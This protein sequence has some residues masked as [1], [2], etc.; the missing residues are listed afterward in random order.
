MW[1]TIDSVDKYASI[2]DHLVAVCAILAGGWWFWRQAVR[3][4]RV[5]FDIAC[6]F[7]DSK[8]DASSRLAQLEFLLDNTGFVEHR[9][10]DLSFSI[11]GLEKISQKDE[12]A[13]VIFDRQIFNRVIIVPPDYNYFFVRPGV[14][15]SIVHIV[16]IPRD[17]D[18][19][20]VTAVFTYNYDPDNPHTMRRV[21]AVEAS[22][23]QNPVA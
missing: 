2:A 1:P 16:A 12:T 23:S 4:P 10:Y 22:A 21:F 15:Q 7:F 14:K 9:V 19:I 8:N 3:T 18:L 20:R 6:R 17:L 5:S 13:E 11:H